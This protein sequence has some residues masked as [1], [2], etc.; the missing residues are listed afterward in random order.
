MQEINVKHGFLLGYT[1]SEVPHWAKT[2]QVLVKMNIQKK[3]QPRQA[4]GPNF[5]VLPLHVNVE[6]SHQQAE[7]NRLTQVMQQG[8]A[9]RSALV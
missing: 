9:E 8:S 7:I 1:V 4:P 3:P 6:L 5:P 2:F